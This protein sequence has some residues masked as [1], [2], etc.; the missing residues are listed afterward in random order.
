M[1]KNLKRKNIL[2]F[3]KWLLRILITSDIEWFEIFINDHSHL[4]EL[5]TESMLVVSQLLAL[6]ALTLNS[7]TKFLDL[8]IGTASVWNKELTNHC[9]PFHI[10]LIMLFSMISNKVW[11]S[12]ELRRVSTIESSDMNF[13]LWLRDVFVNHHCLWPYAISFFLLIIIF[14]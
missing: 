4:M 2:Q 6:I 8:F 9:W 7:V 11:N 10:D 3:F 5:L 1:R 12:I 13:T 14:Q